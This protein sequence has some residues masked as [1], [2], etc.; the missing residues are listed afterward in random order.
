MDYTVEV[1]IRTT[2]ALTIRTLESV[3]SIGG[4]AA[5]NPGGRRVETTLTVTASDI[6][7]AVAK[8]IQSV[9]RCVAG[10]VIA[11]EGMTTAEAD[12]RS[13][14]WRRR[15]LKLRALYAPQEG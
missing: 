9:K 8:G 11:A 12:R 6:P 14:E 15:N 13:R 10:T 1:A 2:H 3:A 5:G 4:V 7:C